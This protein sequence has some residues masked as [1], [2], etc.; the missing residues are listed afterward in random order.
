MHTGE[1]GAGKEVAPPWVSPGQ[2]SLYLLHWFCTGREWGE[3]GGRGDTAR[4]YRR[5]RGRGREV[6]SPWVSPGQPSLYLLHWFP[7]AEKRERGEGGVG[8]RGEGERQRGGREGRQRGE[9]ERQRGGGRGERGGRVRDREGG[10]GRDIER[11]GGN[12]ARAYR[13]GLGRS[14]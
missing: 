11:G 10:G 5:G 2:P 1:T 6:A 9:G 13:Q 4:A 8:E 12:T 3:R 7:F 14:R